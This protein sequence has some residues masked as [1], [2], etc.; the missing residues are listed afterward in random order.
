M[1]SSASIS[2]MRRAKEEEL[3]EEAFLRSSSPLEGE[4]T[5][6]KL[7]RCGTPAAGEPSTP[8]APLPN[9][10]MAT[11]AIMGLDPASRCSARSNAVAA[12]FATS[13]VLFSMS[14]SARQRSRRSFS[15][16]FDNFVMSCCVACNSLCHWF[17]SPCPALASAGAGDC[18]L[19][20]GI[21][22]TAFAAASAAA[23]ESVACAARESTSMIRFASKLMLAPSD[24]ESFTS[25]R[26]STMRRSAASMRRTKPETVSATSAVLPPAS[27]I[28]VAST[29]RTNWESEPMTSRPPPLASC[30]SIASTRRVNSGSESTTS[31]AAGVSG[32]VGGCC[33]AVATMH[34]VL[35]AKPSI[36]ATSRVSTA[37]NFD[38]T[39]ATSAL[40]RPCS[41]LTSD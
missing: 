4:V 11:L 32:R 13:S 1:R 39:L 36:R 28:S 41:S 3:K 25:L 6:P 5:P 8:E 30:F 23:A 12:A 10:A 31:F 20:D 18:A 38:A 17:N 29:R 22:A 40:R 15:K 9:A 24:L 37:S 19:S 14:A 27:C 33:A 34:A 2:P 35:S 21:C 7:R 26:D 16:S